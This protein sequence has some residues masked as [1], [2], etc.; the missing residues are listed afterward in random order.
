[1]I[2]ETLISILLFIP[3]ALMD[4]LS[5]VGAIAIP[6]SAFNWWDNT[7]NMLT[8]VFPVYAVLPILVIS[9]SIKAFQIA[10]A[11]VLRVKS[12]IPTMGA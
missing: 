6:D 8:Y 3:K 10:W 11:I 2:V 4:N 7:I 12:F 1:M 9:F 5:S